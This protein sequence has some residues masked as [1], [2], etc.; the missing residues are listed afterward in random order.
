MQVTVYP[1]G[2]TRAVQSGPLGIPWGGDPA[3]IT[4]PKHMSEVGVLT[5][6]KFS[7]RYEDGFG[8]HDLC[9]WTVEDFGGYVGG[10][11][12][13]GDHVRVTHGGGVCWEGEYSEATPNEDGSVTMH[14]RG[15]A[16]NLLEYDSIY[17]DQRTLPLTD[18]SYPTTALGTVGDDT[19]PFYGWTYAIYEL[20]MPIAQVVG[21]MPFG[22]VG[23]DAAGIMSPVPVKIGTILTSLLQEVGKRWAVWGRTLVIAED[24]MDP[25]WSFAAPESVVAVADT[26]YVTDLGVWYV[27][28]GPEEWDNLTAYVAGDVVLYDGGFY[29]ALIDNSGTTPT[30]EGTWGQITYTFNPQDFNVAWA[31]DVAGKKRFDVRTEV[32]DYRGLGLTGSVWADNMAAQVLAMTKGRWVYTGSFTVNPSSGFASANGGNAGEQLAFVRA[33]RA[34]RLKGLRTS[35]GNLMPDGDVVMIGRTEYEWERDE[36]ESLT[37]TPMGAVPRDVQAALEGKPLDATLVAAG[38]AHRS[39]RSA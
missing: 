28:E 2:G 38:G 17:L 35:Q 6:V 29:E 16:Y 12:R 31:R 5:S 37:I 18:I 19:E 34:V 24:N 10:M 9:E 7:T 20:G 11:F 8:G 14:A 1:R 3:A 21:S 36:S 15:Y 27:E 30:D 39:R 32:V 23:G 25:L 4:S 33:S 26:E 13:P 22:P